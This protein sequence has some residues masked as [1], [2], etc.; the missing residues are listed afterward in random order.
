MEVMRWGKILFKIRNLEK[1][2]AH[3]FGERTRNSVVEFNYCLVLGVQGM[4]TWGI[5]F[6]FSIDN[7]HG[8]GW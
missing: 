6:E 2:C 1:K 7:L 5:F 8:G 4:G 3:I